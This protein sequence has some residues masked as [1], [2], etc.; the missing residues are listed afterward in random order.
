MIR[1]LTLGAFALAIVQEPNATPPQAA[2]HRLTHSV[3]AYASFRSDGRSLV[4]Q[5]NPGGN[6]D[7]YTIDLDGGEPKLLLASSADDITPRWSPDG[8][9]LMF[10]SERDGNPEIYLCDEH[11]GSLRNLTKSP[12]IDIHPCWSHDGKRILFTS[13]RDKLHDDDFSIYAMNSD[14]SDV[15]RIT[16]GPEIDT[17]A[18]WSP[19][20]ARIVTR[21]QIGDDSEVFVLDADGTHPLDISNDPKA[22]DGWPAWSPDGKRIA[23]A[24]GGP[25]DGNHFIFLIDA[26]GKNRV[27]L[28]NFWSDPNWCYDT[29]PTFSPDGKR[30]VFT[31]YEKSTD[32]ERAR[33]CILDVPPPKS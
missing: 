14:G 18:S 1:A 5:S 27:Q 16:H 12:S 8:K 24:G 26:D 21:R 30:L 7:L 9:T 10:V 19:D 15:K 6:F 2:W 25:D 29:Q 28:T 20:D 31:R 11:G 33:L 4:Y 3:D 32:Y 23:W 17:Y 22:F 13:N